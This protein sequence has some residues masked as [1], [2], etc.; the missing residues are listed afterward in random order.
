MNNHNSIG[1]KDNIHVGHQPKMRET[2]AE[3]ILRY[4]REDDED[5]KQEEKSK[6][7]TDPK[8]HKKET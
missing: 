3:R 7:P 6:T 8:E 2:M 5:D 4:W 1:H